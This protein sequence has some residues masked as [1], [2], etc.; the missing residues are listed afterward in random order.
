MS[1]RLIIARHGNTFE[2]G[3]E[4][5]RV[6]IRTDLPLTDKGRAQAMAIGRWLKSHPPLP[7]AIFCG[8]LSRV[9]NTAALAMAGAGLAL[10][11]QPDA[12]FNEIDY[13]PDENRPEAD[14]A[15]RLGEKAL[16]DWEE[17]AIPPS[18]W[19][20]NPGI[21]I[22]DW[23]NFAA[24]LS[25]DYDGCTILA[26]TSNGIARFAPYITGDFEGFRKKYPLKIGTG[27]VCVLEGDKGKWAV[28]QWNLRPE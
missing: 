21:I 19:H 26:V 7:A 4:P 10:H 13:G 20:A 12:M 1:V 15:K 25:S 3:E 28:R 14:V 18:G 23:K 9:R 6:G 8:R 24:R 27:A 17:R 22:S 11:I 5:R 2:D 16:K